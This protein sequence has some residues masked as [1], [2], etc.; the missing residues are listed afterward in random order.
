MKVIG[1]ERSNARWSVAGTFRC[2]S[3]VAFSSRVSRFNL[4]LQSHEEA[5]SSKRGGGGMAWGWG[6]GRGLAKDEGVETK[7]CWINQVGLTDVAD[8]TA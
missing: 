7:Q 1:R 5:T 4:Q 6:P 2:F 8:R 3:T